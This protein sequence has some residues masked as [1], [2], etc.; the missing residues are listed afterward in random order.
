MLTKNYWNK[1]LNPMVENDAFIYQ[2]EPPGIDQKSKVVHALITQERIQ[3]LELLIHL[4]SNLGQAL[5]ICGPE[6]IGK[7]T[8]LK[9]LQETN[10][11]PW[12]YCPVQGH[13]D[14]SFEQIEDRIA[15]AVGQDQPDKPTQAL[16]DVFRRAGSKHKKIV[17]MIDD[18]GHLAPGL[19]D[20]IIEYATDH[21]VLRVIFA[22][23]HDDLYVKNRSDAAVDDC[24]LIEIPPLSE[25]Q[26]GEFLQHLSANPRSKIAFNEIND[27]MIEAVYRQTHGIPGRIAAEFPDVEAAKKSANPFG[28]LVAAVAGLVVLALVIQWFSN[29]KYNTKPVLASVAEAPKPAATETAAPPPPAVETPLEQAAGL[30]EQAAENAVTGNL[31]KPGTAPA[32]IEKPEINDQPIVDQALNDTPLKPTETAN[33]TPAIIPPPDEESAEVQVDQ[34][35]GEQWLMEQPIDNYTLQ[36]MVLSKEQTMQAVVMKYPQLGQNLRYIKEEAHGRPRFVL[37]YGSFTGLSPALQA[38]KSLPTEFRQAV[39]R[40]I[41]AIKK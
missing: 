4:L 23:T 25:Q 39:A 27:A 31:S 38:K 20:K 6:G 2:S 19:I 37:F 30:P 12:L 34:N 22:L 32:I 40:K 16:A 28:M 8:V 21:P 17:L 18:A 26:C 29:S 9:V 11:E 1:R 41:S 35:E 15:A 3:K 33:N 24:H 36:V 5:I 10:V 7:S 13:A 14:L